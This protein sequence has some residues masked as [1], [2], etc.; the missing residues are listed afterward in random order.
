MKPTY[1]PLLLLAKGRGDGRSLL[2]QFAAKGYTVAG[3]RHQMLAAPVDAS[4][5]DDEI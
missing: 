2:A 4:D 5:L 1:L 3:N